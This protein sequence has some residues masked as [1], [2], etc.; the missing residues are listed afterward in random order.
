V[1]IIFSTLIFILLG[2]PVT[3]LILA[4]AFNGL[5]LPIAL[6]VILIAA[7][8]TKIMGSYKHPLWMQVAGWLVVIAMTWMGWITITTSLS[9]LF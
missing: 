5:I 7:T 1:F 8:K 6:A 2:N 9:R 3:L 4:G